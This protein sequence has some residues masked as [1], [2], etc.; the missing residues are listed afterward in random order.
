MALTTLLDLVVRRMYEAEIDADAACQRE[1]LDAASTY[2]NDVW[3]LP[4]QL[5]VA[6]SI[7]LA[8]AIS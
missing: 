8:A 4:W 7:R 1:P 2:A 6:K 3:H 5:A